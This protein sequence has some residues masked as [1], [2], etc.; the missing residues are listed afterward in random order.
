MSPVM[1]N[2]MRPALLL[3]AVLALGSNSLLAHRETLPASREE[4]SMV[5]ASRRLQSEPVAS[6]TIQLRW[7]DDQGG[8]VRVTRADGN[9]PLPLHGLF[10]RPAGWHSMP[11]A[12]ELRLPPGSYL[13]E[14]TRSMEAIVSRKKVVLKHGRATALT[15]E[16]ARF[17]N[18]E[19]RHF[20]AVNTHLHLLLR[21]RLKMGVDLA[22][23]AEADAY[24]RTVGETD[25]LDL[26]Y[27]SYLT[28][29]GLEVVSNE[30][31]A[32]D[33]RA[34]STGAT[35]FADAIEH[36]HGG[37]RIKVASPPVT[38]GEKPVYTQDDSKVAVSYGHVLLLGVDRHHVPAS[39]GPGLAGVPGAT[40][41]VPLR[42]GLRL[43]GD[44][45]GATV[46][47]HGSHGVEW[48]PSW[49][50]GVLHAQNIYDGG[51]E[52]TFETVHYPLLNAGLRVPFSAGSD[53]GVW[54]FSRVMVA[55]RQPLTHAVFLESL[56]AGRT[57]ITNEPFLEF[58]VEGAEPGDTVA[59]ERAR[60]VRVRGR[61]VARSD[62]IRL[63]LVQNGR[64]LHEAACRTVDGHHEAEFEITVPL[65]EPGWLALRVPPEMPYTIR[66]RY[67]GGGVN[68][69][70]KAIFAHTSPVYVTI[71]GQGLRDAA[72]VQ[73]LITRV[74][75]AL[76]TIDEHG[77]FSDAAER[78][79][80]RGLY[81]GARESLRALLRE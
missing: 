72:A 47:C 13:I 36:R 41:G 49:M 57:Y 26:V 81:T 63:Q 9:E 71:A 54:D 27:V 46:W 73:D 29:P 5:D 1:L 74:E 55:S 79:T 64:V 51:S 53:W 44:N 42:D 3:C 58:T 6:A 50:G 67:E 75:A 35:R 52:G 12:T 17:Y 59:L 66:S 19:A 4:Q 38:P 31:T 62:F 70:G 32:D 15:L 39:L 78:E 10:E 56:A 18:S 48:I 7:K 21:A 14:A 23:R 24:L 22:S 16:A 61:A 68:I 2:E 34:F 69:F 25:G 30:Y 11:A 40:D 77:L 8:L 45:G 60:Q 43:A 76:A 65:N 80:V 20:R 33:L 28:Q 37:V